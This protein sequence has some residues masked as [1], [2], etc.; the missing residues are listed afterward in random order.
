M[1]VIG[2]DPHK[3]THTATAVDP[4]TNRDLGSI[5]IRSSFDDYAQLWTWATQWP[6][7]IWAVENASG[8][9]HHLTQWLIG[10]GEAVVDIPPTATARVRELSRGGRRK[11]DRIDAAA[12]A[13]VAFSHGDFRPVAPEDHTDVLRILDERR[14]DLVK[15]NGRLI[16]QLHA[17][18]RELLPGGIECNLD[19]E[20]AA[21]ELKRFRPGTASDAMRKKVGLEIVGDLRRLRFQID[22]L[23]DRIKTELTA[24]GT[25][26]QKIPGVGVVT[27]ARILARTGNP[28]RFANEGAYANYTGT[29]PVEI[30]SADKQR[31]RLSRGGDRTLNSA[32]HIV[33]VTQARTTTSAGHAYHRRKVAEGK[34]HREAT[35]CLKRQIVKTLWRTMQDD[36]VRRVEEPITA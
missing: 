6:D 2:I 7:R 17:I 21:T 3:S 12:A 30:A 13:C 35:L 22:D 29:A 26:L 18:M 33:A 16:N 28:T 1:F 36:F 24:C 11:N 5:R 4:D 25:R 9:G 8:L 23:T 27:A 19:T 34:T 14:I 31:H 15:Q 20:H 10:R 32:I